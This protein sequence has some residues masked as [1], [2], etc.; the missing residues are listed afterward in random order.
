M[1]RSTSKA[2]ISSPL[3]GMFRHPCGAWVRPVR[4]RSG[5]VWFQPLPAVTR[6]VVLGA[7][8]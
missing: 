4:F 3:V 6:R 7:A 2:A 8:A 5:G 1:N